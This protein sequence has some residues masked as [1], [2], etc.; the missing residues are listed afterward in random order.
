VVLIDVVPMTI[1][2]GMPGGAFK[3]IIER[4]TPLP[5]RSRS[6]CPPRPTARR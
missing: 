5:S 3:R 6:A 2:V 4:N 1:G